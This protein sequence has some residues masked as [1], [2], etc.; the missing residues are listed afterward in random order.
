MTLTQTLK[1][2]KASLQDLVNYMKNRP[3]LCMRNKVT[4]TRKEIFEHKHF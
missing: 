3:T 1:K 2:E 4:C